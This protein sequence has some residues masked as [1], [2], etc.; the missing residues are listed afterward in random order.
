[1]ATDIDQFVRE[2]HSFRERKVILKELRSGI[3]KPFPKVR[4][5]IKQRA[6]ATL[7]KRGG[8]NVWVSKIRVSLAVKTGANKVTVT[9][10]GGRNSSGGRSDMKAMDRGR[11]RHPSWGRR[12]I[13]QWHNQAVPAGFFTK[14]VEEANEWRDEAVASVDR[15]TEELRRG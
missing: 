6:L 7:P 5:A 9:V 8:L 2:L 1:M 10:K 14:P 13:G 11:V 12:G 15:A 4:A 3:R